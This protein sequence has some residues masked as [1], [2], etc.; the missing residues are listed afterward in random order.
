[1]CRGRL[2][3]RVASLRKRP[4]VP[5]PLRRSLLRPPTTTTGALPTAIPSPSAQATPTA[6]PLEATPTPLPATRP[7]LPAT[8]QA[9]EPPRSVSTAA[10]WLGIAVVPKDRCSPHDPDDYGYSRRLN[11]G[12]SRS[13]AV[14]MDPTRE[15]GSTESGR[16]ALSISSSVQRPMTAACAQL[17]E[18][19]GLNSHPIS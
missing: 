11:R 16:Q 19:S 18:Q 14:S 15:G 17:A 7:A 10:T 1:M 6:V 2:H 5:R 8:P 12:S 13:W 4:T 3:L 9:I